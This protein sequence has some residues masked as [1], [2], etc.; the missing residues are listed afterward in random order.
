MN[1]SSFQLFFSRVELGLIQDDIEQHLLYRFCVVKT[2]IA[3]Q[4]QKKSESIPQEEASL[5]PMSDNGQ[6]QSF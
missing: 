3:L 4:N 5:Q 1:L 6:L 2:L